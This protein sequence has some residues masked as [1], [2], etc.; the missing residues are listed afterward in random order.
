ME[1]LLSP[2]TEFTNEKL[3]Q[4]LSFC[5]V[6]LVKTYSAKLVDFSGFIQFLEKK[7]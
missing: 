3:L 4:E 5:E 2:R 1:E 6:A 7:F